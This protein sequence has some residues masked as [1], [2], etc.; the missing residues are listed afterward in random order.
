MAK[1]SADKKRLKELHTKINELT[2]KL[3]V[4]QKLEGKDEYIAV[5]V[6][7]NQARFERV[8]KEGAKDRAL[9]NFYL[10]I[11][12]TAKQ[13]DVFVPVSMA[14]GKK[15]AGFMYQIEGEASGSIVTANITPRGKGVSQ[16]TVGTL[17]FAKIPASTTASFE[18]RATIQGSF[19]KAYKIVITRLNYK[20][21]LSEVRYQQYLKEIDSK[22][23]VFS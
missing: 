14:S 18:V 23:V 8:K 3:E 11:D 1:T 22:E 12:I 5:K 20:L 7:K 4:A 13:G 2:S 9:G 16:V 10:E 21:N 19:G 17:L 15:T 6:R